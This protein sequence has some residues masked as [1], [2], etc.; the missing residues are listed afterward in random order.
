M[1]SLFFDNDREVLN[2]QNLL[3]R[4]YGRF[5]CTAYASVQAELH[6]ITPQIPYGASSVR[7]PVAIYATD[8]ANEGAN[9][10]AIAPLTRF[11][12]LPVIL[13]W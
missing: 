12:M 9:A 10:E 11:K 3:N 4:A 7:W 8:N 1:F 2:K 13:F 6:N 5:A